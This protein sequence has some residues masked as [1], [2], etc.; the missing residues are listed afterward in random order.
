[1]SEYMNIKDWARI[2]WH[3]DLFIVL[4][5][6]EYCIGIARLLCCHIIKLCVVG[7]KTVFSRT[8]C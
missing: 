3:D 8:R 4:L 5:W 7:L 2:Y 6:S 1:M